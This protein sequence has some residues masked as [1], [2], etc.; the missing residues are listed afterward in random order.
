MF[1]SPNI[2]GY[3][4]DW[5][6]DLQYLSIVISVLVFFLRAKFWK[7]HGLIT[8]ILLIV[9]II[10]LGYLGSRFI[11]VIESFLTNSV[12]IQK[13]SFSELMLKYGGMRW[14]GALLF[15]FI[16]FYLIIKI[17]KKI[18]MLNLIDEVVLAASIG[19][20]IGKVG[21]WLSGHGCYGIPTNLPW[22]M[23]FPYGTMPSFLPVHPTPLYDAMVYFILFF[24]LVWLGKSKKY[25]GQLVVNFLVVSSIA[26]VLIET[27][28]TNEAV[29]FNLSLA[30]I[31]YIVLLIGTL[32]FYRIA[33]KNQVNRIYIQQ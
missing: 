1:P 30:Q 25:L 23:R 13:Y 15:N 19:L 8:V 21:C 31:I 20:V 7:E 6:Q 28:R 32:I 29:I 17:T 4:V 12:S 33:K 2:F 5:F 16:A 10:L 9:S 3:Q 18:N 11:E 27:I 26:S 24:Y 22:G 14:Y